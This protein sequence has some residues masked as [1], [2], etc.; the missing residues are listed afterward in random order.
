MLLA[1]L[2]VLAV[3]STCNAAD[4]PER[5]DDIIR[6]LER[7]ERVVFNAE[8]AA[9]V[10]EEL[11]ELLPPDD[12][13]RHARLDGLKCSW[14]FPRQP[15]E[16]LAFAEA[17]LA[18]YE[19]ARHAAGIA[20]ML[21]CRAL[22]KAESGELVDGLADLHTAVAA[23]STIEDPLL[24]ADMLRSRGDA[25]SFQ[26]DFGPA[27]EDL[28][29]AHGLLEG[30]GE[31]ELA[32]Q[33]DFDIGAVYRRLGAYEEAFPF[34]RREIDAAEGTGNA[35]RATMAHLQL[36]F[37]Y[38][39]QGDGAQS[40]SSFRRGVE[41]ARTT[42]SEALIGDSLVALGMSLNLQG[43]YERALAALLEAQASHERV[44]YT[45]NHVMTQLQR[46][47]AFAGLGRHRE[48]VAEFETVE[49]ALVER[50]QQRFLALLYPA[51]AESLEATGRL[52]EALSDWRAHNEV[53]QRLDQ[54]SQRHRADLLRVQ[55]DV[56]RREIE[57]E[58][59]RA[60]TLLQEER[61]KAMARTRTWQTLSLALAVV[62][63]VL[64]SLALGALVVRARRLQVMAMTDQLTGVANRRRVE[65][66]LADQLRLHRRHGR[67][68]SV[69]SLDIDHFKRINDTSGHPAGD[70]VLQRVGRVGEE[71][72][73]R[74]GD[75]IGRTGGEEFLMVL[76]GTPMEAAMMVAERLRGAV[77][78]T[79]TSD[80]I[81]QPNVTISLGVAIAQ[82]GDSV[83]D[84]EARVDD[85]LYRAKQ[86]GRNRVEVSS[87]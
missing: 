44:D 56:S 61:F 48:A 5:F 55:F 39:E 20:R 11:V 41:R 81:Q 52:A 10:I 57:N 33:L 82:P 25:R 84:L 12:L 85:A 26:G 19:D 63:G 45:L 77:E 80:V 8:S 13:D 24:L 23:A 53:R 86:G 71:S 28:L 30:V 59:L 27:L 18:V 76:P 43:E 74:A 72:L 17:R 31:P 6:S 38:F 37:A 4:D 14:L 70:I 51:R 22:L 47:V 32:G 75:L 66:Y 46:G 36:G 3:G 35:R 54:R 7:S 9:P 83:R 1:V 16:S 40:E 42:G 87:A 50:D 62:L 67:P 78:A 68:L 79:D 15:R 60:E 21:R 2:A 29:A 58:R 34:L 49:P 69:I 65:L 73:L 64:L